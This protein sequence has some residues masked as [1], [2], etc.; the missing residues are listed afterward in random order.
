MFRVILAA[1][2]LLL[3]APAASA[4]APFPGD[5]AVTAEHVSFLE[6]DVADTYGHVNLLGLELATPLAPGVDLVLGLAYGSADGNPHYLDPTFTATEAAEA[7]LIP[8]T[9]GF[10]TDLSR[11]PHLRFLLSAAYQATWVEERYGFEESGLCHGLVLGMGPEWNLAD[12]R[13]GLGLD[14]RWRGGSGE[15]GRGYDRHTFNTGGFSVRAG[16][17]RRFGAATSE[18]GR[19]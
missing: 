15:L 12:G 2:A 10:R 14:V 4:A 5:L 19:S 7:T 17:H 3:A 16:L 1:A 9:M 8:M 11:M 6:D 18:G 13:W